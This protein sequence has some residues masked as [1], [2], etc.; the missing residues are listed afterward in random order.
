MIP[1][2]SFILY[3][4]LKPMP[5]NK[6][7]VSLF[8]GQNKGVNSPKSGIQNVAMSPY[9]IHDGVTPT[10]VSKLSAKCSTDNIKTAS[11]A[12]NVEEAVWFLM[13]AAY[14]QE[15][16]AKDFL[17]AKGIEVFLPM[18]EKCIVQNGKRKNKQVS[19]I[20]NFLFVKS[21]EAE[22]KK[23]VGKGE[24]GFFHH[25]Y[26]PYR[27]E[28]GRM[29]GRKGI[30]PLVIPAKQMNF[31]I[32]WNAVE[33]EDKLFVPD[34]K[35]KFTKDDKVKIVRGKFVGFEGKVCRIK[36]QTRVGLII[37]GVGTIFTTY[38]P[39]DYLEKCANY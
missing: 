35:F 17:E 29:V 22:M 9:N 6:R 4:N 24:L 34:A 21:T 13:R 2:F 5:N 38:I 26:V 31:F 11:S 36:G 28:A 15:K 30:K 23:Y 12:A 8:K 33:E 19:L 37:E 39:K 14:G 27:D 16:K 7:P 1:A 20:P 3:K 25:Y 10:Y 32:K 18:Q